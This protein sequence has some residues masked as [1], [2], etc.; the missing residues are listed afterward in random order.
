MEAKYLIVAKNRRK[1]DKAKQDTVRVDSVKSAPHIIK[2][3]RSLENIIFT[4][5]NLRSDT[6]TMEDL[7]DSVFQGI[8]VISCETLKYT[9]LYLG[10]NISD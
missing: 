9:F 5:S 8:L 10:V 4:V 6:G 3:G 2:R 1:Q 7:T